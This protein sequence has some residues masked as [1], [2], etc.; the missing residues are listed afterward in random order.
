MV[1]RRFKYKLKRQTPHE[2]ASCSCPS[3]RPTST[4]S[5]NSSPSS[6]IVSRS[7]KRTRDEL[8]EAI[9]D[10]LKTAESQECKNYFSKAGYIETNPIPL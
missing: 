8:C 9:G 10:I 1:A 3:T 7:R 2:L 5:S 6:S 4:R